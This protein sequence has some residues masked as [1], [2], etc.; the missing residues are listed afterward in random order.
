MIRANLNELIVATARVG[1]NQHWKSNAKQVMYTS[2]VDCK[3][4][5]A[6]DGVD[7][8]RVRVDLYCVYRE[9][10]VRGRRCAEAPPTRVDQSTASNSSSPVCQSTPSRV[11]LRGRLTPS[12]LRRQARPP[13][14]TRGPPS[15]RQRPSRRTAAARRRL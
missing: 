3:C 9:P 2:I 15:R 4:H 14:G 5:Q 11:L 13:R 12:T 1:P 10:T 6:P 8:G 7:V